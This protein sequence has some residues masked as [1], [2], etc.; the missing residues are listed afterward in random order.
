MKEN[1]NSARTNKSK[2]SETNSAGLEEFT[3]LY[4]GLWRRVIWW[5]LYTDVSEERT[6]SIFMVEEKAN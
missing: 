1:N 5:M 3:A 2:N 6:A 4:S